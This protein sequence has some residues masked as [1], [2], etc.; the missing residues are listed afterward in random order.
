M[1]FI[2]ARAVIQG[3]MVQQEGQREALALGLGYLGQPSMIYFQDCILIGYSMARLILSGL[4]GLGLGVV[5]RRNE[6]DITP[7]FSE[8]FIEQGR[9]LGQK[10]VGEW[11]SE[12]PGFGESELWKL[13]RAIT[14]ISM[15]GMLLGN[16]SLSD[17]MSGALL[18]L[19]A[20]LELQ[21]DYIAHTLLE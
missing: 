5:G 8:W 15:G 2:Y 13:V 12:G 3:R 9:K 18:I 20:A 4:V 1:G 17:A 7:G 14:D 19:V 11:Q 16:Y 21:D 6:M 10:R